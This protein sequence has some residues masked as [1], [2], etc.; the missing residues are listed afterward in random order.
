MK[1]DQTPS[2]DAFY[3]RKQIFCKDRFI[4]WSHRSRFE[5]GRHLVSRFRGGTLLDYGCGDGT[6]LGLVADMFT[7]AVGAD[8]GD[9]SLESCRRRFAERP[10]LSFVR[11]DQLGPEHDGQYDVVTCME[12]L[13]HCIPE[14]ID[15][16]LTTMRRLV[17][18]RGRII[19]SVPI[20]IGPSL[21]LK[22]TL[23]TVAAW[24]NLGDYKYKERYRPAE[25]ARMV[26]ATAGTSIQRN[27][28]PMNDAGG[29]DVFY[30]HKG[31]NWRT[32]RKELERSFEVEQ[33]RFSPLPVFAGFLSSQ[34]WFVCK[35]R[36]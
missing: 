4:A 6:F 30:G 23:R 9:Q 15:F 22:E 34:V 20:E 13:E 14:S 25:L 26:F 32:F 8:V 10:E 12:V 1:T 2:P 35:P 29:P 18:P 16:A 36:A 17:S 3:A 7:K 28:G 5:L 21:L 11:I 27:R 33:P 24:R 31:F 19:I